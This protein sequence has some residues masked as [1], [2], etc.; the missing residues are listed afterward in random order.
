VHPDPRW[1]HDSAPR[2]R[3]CPGASNTRGPWKPTGSIRTC[4]WFRRAPSLQGPRSAERR[5]HGQFACSDATRWRFQRQRT[6]ARAEGVVRLHRIGRN[7]IG[8]NRDRLERRCESAGTFPAGAIRG[9]PSQWARQR[10][11]V[12]APRY[13]PTGTIRPEPRA[14][15]IVRARTHARSGDRFASRQIEWPFVGRADREPLPG[16][17]VCARVIGRAGTPRARGRRLPGRLRGGCAAWFSTAARRGVQATPSNG[18][19]RSWT[20][21]RS[22]SC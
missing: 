17:V 7:R 5:G 20:C 3:F 4:G 2:T 9:A 15:A 22:A 14:S 21:C 10:P 1:R 18:S 19:S 6:T 11:L 13:P 8:R 12:V 16:Q